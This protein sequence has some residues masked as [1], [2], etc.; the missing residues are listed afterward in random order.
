MSLHCGVLRELSGQG[1]REGR[2]HDRGPD[3][4]PFAR[5]HTATITLKLN[6]AAASR[7]A[8]GHTAQATLSAISVWNRY[9]ATVV[10]KFRL[11]LG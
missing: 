10:A 7:A 2:Q 9:A 3:A 4:P 8:H 1:R 6:R 11:A 5:N